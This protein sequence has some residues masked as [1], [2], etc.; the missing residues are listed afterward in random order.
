MKFTKIARA[1]FSAN[2]V[3]LFVFAF[4]PLFAIKPDAAFLQTALEYLNKD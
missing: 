3:L 2:F 4:L 1:L